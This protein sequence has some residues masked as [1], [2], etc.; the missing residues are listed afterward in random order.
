MKN[1]EELSFEEMQRVEG[2]LG[3]WETVAAGLIVATVVAIIDDWDNFK[4]GLQGKPE[5]KR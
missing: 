3:F 5:I 4:A 1:F 2:G